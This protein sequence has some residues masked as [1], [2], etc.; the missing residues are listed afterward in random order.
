MTTREELIAL[1]TTYLEA[2]TARDL[3]RLPTTPTVRFTE[4]G[5]ELPLGEGLWETAG[6]PAG[7]GNYFTDVNAG[8]VGF[9][10]VANEGDK[11]LILGLRLKV[12]DGRIAEVESV[13]SRPRGD[14]FRPESV[15]VARPAYEEVLAPSQRRSRAELVAITHSYFNGIEHRDGSMIL[16]HDDCARIENGTITANRPADAAALGGNPEM[17]RMA[18]IGVAAQISAGIHGYISRVRDRRVLAV[19]EERGMTFGVYMF[20][21]DGGESIELRDG[22]RRPMP[23]FA[24]NPSTVMIWEVFKIKDGLIT[25]VEAIGTTLPHGTKPGWATGV[26]A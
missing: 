26:A 8:Q 14:M 15:R 12:E 21:H 3:S 24:R 9:F 22:T 18:Q 4:N 5:R 17:A 6:S 16:V 23:E 25:A 11:A 20:D 7:S 10:G 1:V 13:V 2:L 19:D